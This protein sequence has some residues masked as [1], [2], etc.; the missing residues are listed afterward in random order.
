MVHVIP[1]GTSEPQDFQLRNDGSALVG[2]GLVVT[3]AIEDQSGAVIG[4]PPTVAWLSEAG[5][6]VRVL[7]VEALPVGTYTVRFELTDGG[8]RLGFVPNR[9]APDVWRVV[10]IH[11]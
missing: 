6:T 2:S 11:A 3:L 10:P 5:G 4:T 8:G 1:V 9:L 7:G